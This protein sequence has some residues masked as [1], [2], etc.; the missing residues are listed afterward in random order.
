MFREIN[1]RYC[2]KIFHL[3]KGH[4]AENNQ[5]MY[6][7]VLLQYNTISTMHKH[8]ATVASYRCE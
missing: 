7:W 5:R 4:R 8:A 3:V 1:A 6:S 2:L